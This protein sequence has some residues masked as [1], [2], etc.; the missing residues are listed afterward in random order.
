VSIVK[1]D[2]VFADRR[3]ALEEE[4]FRKQDQKLI[5]RLRV[6]ES[7]KALKDALALAGSNL[8]DAVVD[9]LV[10]HGVTAETLTSLTL[11]P[12]VAV[13]W[14]DGTVERKEREAVLRAADEKGIAAGTAAHGLLEA[15]LSK[16]PDSKLVRAWEEYIAAIVSTLSAEETKS[17]KAD[18]LDRARQV[19]SAAGGFLGIGPRIS[20]AEQDVLDKLERAFEGPTEPAA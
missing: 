4:F 15:W 18:I 8:S 19:A 3:K 12:L 10:D 5:E 11:I 13:A 1:K 2:E 20:A 7:K 17:L 9:R 14:A 6:S 16:K